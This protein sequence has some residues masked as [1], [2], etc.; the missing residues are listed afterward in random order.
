MKDIQSSRDGKKAG[1]DA[2]II[3]AVEVED[4][5][6]GEDM[7]AGS[8]ERS[9]ALL[10]PDEAPVLSIPPGDVDELSL[11]V[12]QS[13]SSTSILDVTST[14][15]PTS[16]SPET[17]SA[18]LS[19]LLPSVLPSS[20]AS[21]MSKN[22]VE[23]NTLEERTAIV[24]VS[25]VEVFPEV[26]CSLQEDGSVSITLK[27]EGESNQLGVGLEQAKDEEKTGL[28]R[29]AGGIPV[30][31]SLM[32]GDLGGT[33]VEVGK[34]AREGFIAFDEDEDI[35]FEVDEELRRR[36]LEE[37]ESRRCDQEESRRRDLEEESRRR[38][39]E[40]EEESRRR[41]LEEDSRRRDLEEFGALV[42]GGVGPAQE[43][44]REEVVRLER[45][46]T[47][48]SRAAT[49]VSNVMYKEAQVMVARRGEVVVM[50][51]YQSFS[52]FT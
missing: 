8:A 14:N 13:T 47:Q 6:R 12:V 40:E 23:K 44:L 25:G 29:A 34:M 35:E 24:E 28:S 11:R 31:S 50:L 1:P 3:R 19:S 49:A 43:Q 15:K 18:K 52:I 7:E 21:E 45:E 27:M 36:D 37:E 10:G 17:S 9:L 32:G 39:L 26:S 42:D 20:S 2:A 22:P 5:G 33:V 51:V 48:Q 30:G 41:D 4:E 16:S 38:D 46:R